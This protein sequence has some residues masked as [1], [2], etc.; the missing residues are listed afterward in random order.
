MLAYS[1]RPDSTLRVEY[2]SLDELYAS[3]DVLSLHIPLNEE[4]Y[5]MIDHGAIARMKDGVVLV[6]TARGG[7][8]QTEALIEGLEC[9]KIGAAALDVL[10]DET[11]CS[12]LTRRQS[13]LVIG[14]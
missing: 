14:P 1:R 2:V 10:E 6:N 7:L 11:G 9:G 5:H 12:I 4:S 3:C 13:R 8:I